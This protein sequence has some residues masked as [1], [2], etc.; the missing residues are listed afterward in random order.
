[1]KRAFLIIVVLGFLCACVST[2]EVTPELPKRPTQAELAQ[3]DYGPYP[4]NYEEI[5]LQEL[6]RRLLDPDSLKDFRIIEPPKKSYLKERK[7]SGWIFGYEVTLGYNA[8]NRYGGY[9][10]WK[11]Q[12]A[13]L[14][15]GGVVGMADPALF[16]IF[17]ERR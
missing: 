17:Q 11:S 1:M 2:R 7:G 3:A 16:E 5:L 15:D 4:E 8:K 9:V 14:K 6:E 12:K 10:G 13:L